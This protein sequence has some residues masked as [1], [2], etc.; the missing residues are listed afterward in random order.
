MGG[1]HLNHPLRPNY[2]IFLGKFEKSFGK[3]STRTPYINL[4]PSPRK[5]ESAIEVLSGKSNNCH[6]SI[7]HFT[8]LETFQILKGTVH[9]G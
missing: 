3:L 6:K 8:Q 4:K 5:L 2:I 9:S 7:K 1:V